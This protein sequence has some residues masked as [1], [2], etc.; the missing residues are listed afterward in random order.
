MGKIRVGGDMTPTSKPKQRL[1]QPTVLIIET[2]TCSTELR[3]TSY[4]SALKGMRFELVRCFAAAIEFAASVCIDF[5]VIY[6]NP[7]DD[8]KKVRKQI[9]AVWMYCPETTII[10]VAN[11]GFD[12][13]DTRVKVVVPRSI[14]ALAA[15]IAKRITPEFKPAA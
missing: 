7:W 1:N 12:A 2:Y 6:V 10:L 4:R 3:E 9:S 8:P 11:G 15:E 13:Q 14:D 5:T